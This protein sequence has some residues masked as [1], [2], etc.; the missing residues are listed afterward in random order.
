MG[1]NQHH[2]A[3]TGTG[4]Q[5]VADD[6]A[7]R[8]MNATQQNNSPYMKAISE[9]IAKLSGLQHDEWYQCSKTNATY[10]DCPTVN[11]NLYSNQIVN[12]AVHNPSSVDMNYA[13]ILVPDGLY[14]AK[15]F[16]AET[17]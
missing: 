13:N 1:I 3:V 12:V 8:L 4:K 7:Y 6:Y 11:M 16:N 15:T 17:Q 10:L 2:D 5:A 14:S 9:K